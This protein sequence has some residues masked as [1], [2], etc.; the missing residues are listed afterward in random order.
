[1]FRALRP[2][3]GL[4]QGRIPALVLRWS[5]LRI[6]Q[7]QREALARLTGLADSPGLELLL[8]HV[9]GFPL[10]MAMLTHR[11]YPLPIWNALQIRNRLVLE[12][13]IAHGREHVLETRVA[14][15][16]IL[17]KGAEIDIAT[18]LLGGTR[19]V[20][21][22]KATFFYRGRFV[23]PSVAQEPPQAPEISSDAREAA[24]EMP[25]GGGGA[26]ARMT[27]DY[28]PIHWWGWYARRMRFATRFLHPQRTV[29][30]CMAHLP[31]PASERQSLDLWIKGPVFYGTPAVLRY[32]PRESGARFGLSVAGDP[33]HAIRGEWSANPPA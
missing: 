16:R 20:W 21:R 29:G 19:R 27:G 14:G 7:G 22:S 8:P 30:I 28:N 17:E 4:R 5:G 11:S 9:I 6:E 23:A 2:S 1:M 33:R 31:A 26:M 18:E 24:F 3:A 12:E 32:E 10:T 15:H 25:R 13:R